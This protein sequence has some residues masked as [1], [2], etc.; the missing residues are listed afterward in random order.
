MLSVGYGKEPIEDE[1]LQTNLLLCHLYE[2]YECLIL[3]LTQ[4]IVDG[5]ET[6]KISGIVLVDLSASYNTDY[7]RRLPDKVYI[8]TRYYRLMCG[9]R[10]LLQKRRFVVELRSRWRS[11]RNGIPQKSVFAQLL[12]I[13]FSSSY[14]QT[15]SRPARTVYMRGVFSHQFF[16][17]YTQ[18]ASLLIR[19]LS[20][21][22]V[23]VTLPP[24]HGLCSQE[25]RV[26]AII[27]IIII[28]IY[29]EHI[30]LRH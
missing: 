12:F 4:Y 5:F 18:T 27:I 22:F 3:N 21:L 26:M 13:R 17:T 30:F 25:G 11:R 24:L 2:L 9:V 8:M 29:L 20:V 1:N 28:V 19:I 6:G 15:T 16:S 14:T 7:N 10:T 23:Q